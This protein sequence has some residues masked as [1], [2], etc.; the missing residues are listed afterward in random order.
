MH[1]LKRTGYLVGVL[2][3]S[4]L[5]EVDFVLHSFFDD[6]FEVALLGPLDGD[7]KFVKLAVDEPTEVLYDVWVI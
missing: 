6:E 7:E 2:D 3:N 1:V 5:L 4:L